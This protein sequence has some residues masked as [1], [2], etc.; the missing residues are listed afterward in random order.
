MYV[1]KKVSPS[2]V[3][4]TSVVNILSFDNLTILLCKIVKL[5]TVAGN[6]YFNFETEKLDSI[7]KAQEQSK[8][9]S[10]VVICAWPRNESVKTLWNRHVDII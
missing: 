8:R 2:L 4:F 3:K 7:S 1:F 10:Q 5:L 6:R 9:N